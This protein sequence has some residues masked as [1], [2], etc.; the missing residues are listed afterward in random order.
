MRK[1]TKNVNSGLL[2][3]KRPK[4]RAVTGMDYSGLDFVI[5]LEREHLLSRI[6]TNQIVGF[7][8]SKKESCSMRRRLHVGTNVVEFQ[9][10]Q[11]VGIFS[12]LC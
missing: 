5:F 6:P 1:K 3:S 9:Q 7:R 2:P 11:E 8:R 4:K 12:Y 10:L